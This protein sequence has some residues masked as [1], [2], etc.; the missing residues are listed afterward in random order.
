MAHDSL[1]L[2]TMPP[3]AAF[4][5]H[6]ARTLLADPT[7]RGR[8]SSETRLEDVT[9][10]L[11]TRRAVRALADAFLRAGD[12]KA[13]ILPGITP[14]GDID[15]DELLLDP[16]G[17][18][19]ETLDLPPAIPP[20]MRQMRLARL[21]L[22]YWER[23]SERGVPDIVRALSLAS[24]LGQFLDMGLTEG[25]AFDQLA[26]I[27]PDE[28]AR[29]WQ[30]TIEF[31]AV[32]TEQWPRELDMLGMIDQADRRNRL[33]AGQADRWR[34][35]PPCGPVIAAGSTGSIPA[36]A[37][38]M[39]V[40]ARLA[41]GALVLPGLDLVMDAASWDAIGSPDTA[42]HP[43][44]GL[45]KLLTSLGASR[46]D[47][48][49][50]PGVAT[51]TSPRQRLISEALRPAATTDGWRDI[52]S[53]LAPLADESINGLSF[54]E[55]ANEREEAGAIGL[56]MRHALETP[57]QT[58]ALVTPDR[59]LARRVAM[60]L[61]RWGIA[62][63]DSAGIPLALTPPLVFLRHVADAAAE[64]FAPIPLLALL[65]HPLTALG[66]APART[67]ADARRLEAALLHGPRPGPGI[68]G[69]RGALAQWREER[70]GRESEVQS[71]SAFL[72]RLEQVFAPLID[73]MS[74][75]EVDLAALLA[76][77]VA[78]AERI[79][80]SDE[81]SGALVLWSREAGEAAR[82]FLRDLA[83]A[84]PLMDAAPPRIWP[85]LVTDLAM[86][87]A[88]RPQYGRHPRLAIWSPLEARLQHADI[89]ILGGLNEGIWPTDAKIDPW[90]N[91]PMRTALGLE[92]PERRIGLSA[93]D[94]VEGACATQVF[95]TRALKQGGTPTVAS[96]WLLRLTSLLE[97]LG[98]AD[99]VAA[100]AWTDMA[101]I[102]DRAEDAPVIIKP[103]PAPPVAWRP[104][105][106]SV[107]EIET[108]IRD[109]YAIYARKVL[110][111]RVTDPIDADVAAMDRGNIIHKAL[112]DFVRAYPDRLPENAHQKL[113]AHGRRAF[114]PFL[115]RPGV[116]AFWWPRFVSIV[117][118]FL[119]FEMSHRTG[120]KRSHP[121][122][123]GSIVITDLQ[124]PVTLCGKA[125]R[126]DEANDGSL[127][128][129]DYK[130]GQA[131]SDKQVK[132][133][134]AP[135]LPLEA[136]MA[137]RGGFA[138]FGPRPVS[139]VMHL[140]LKGDGKSDK[141]SRID[142]P[143]GELAEST[144]AEL[145]TLLR[146]YENLTQ[147]YLSRLRPRFQAQIGDYDHLARVREWASA[148]EGDE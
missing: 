4:L 122:I 36:T 39:N 27:V 135:Q 20:L 84:I 72:D 96:R 133:G 58:A 88:L 123:T 67:R 11:P 105:R 25:V 127:I 109:P 119:D 137:V 52:L 136:A 3:G 106:F 2:Y 115:D 92:P 37:R 93:H 8:F 29:N 103:K 111:L 40:V 42:S 86:A 64:D 6:L 18:A 82:D 51:E 102:L 91:R 131:P 45:K 113:L 97:G 90:L 65:K 57:G 80:A 121:E 110:E 87:R 112:E 125:D 114:A 12:G 31:L 69:L 116:A 146:G 7:L 14:L 142:D 43:Q 70:G 62:I 94:F 98:K 50:W 28:F 66:Q 85:R 61:Q 83:D 26:S 129:I 81:T 139:A 38:L 138:E 9:I 104:D 128:I 60:E 79:A 10:L 134:L 59:Q 63:D 144:Y 15:E 32:L 49:I 47:V 30:L 41:Q 148:G 33:L 132:L 118:W 74:A 124:R 78:T 55:A 13:M 34:A 75:R 101:R 56:L 21:I 54:I 76:T 16:V 89:T 5:D 100:S 22:D 117:D 71:I 19:E 73:I 68:A 23:D 147:P 107:T 141:S 140:R 126:I 143:A 24:D 35:T 46:T 145:V 120:I 48:M 95:L 17:L 130:T 77:H 108:L 44:Y 53:E 1:T 99:K